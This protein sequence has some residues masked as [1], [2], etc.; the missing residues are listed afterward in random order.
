MKIVQPSASLVSI[1]P[2]AAH[3][4]E[5]AGRT[6]YKSEGN[7][8]YGTAATFIKKIMGLGHLSVLEHAVASIRIVCDRGISHEIV[9]HRLCSFTQESSRFCTYSK[10]KFDNEISVIEPEFDNPLQ[11][12]MWL[13]A[14]ADAEQ[15]YL[16][17][18]SQ[19]VSNDSARSVLPTCLKTELVLTANFRQWLHIFSL[20]TDDNPHAHYQIRQVME[21]ARDILQKECS[22]VFCT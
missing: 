5:A 14:M 16:W 1:T 13:K 11:R 20:R 4:I 22:E 21:M 15:T 12:D 7:I 10:D 6:A 8:G 17:L 18:K 19:G 2:N 3:V 9:R